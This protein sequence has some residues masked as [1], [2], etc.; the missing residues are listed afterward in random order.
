MEQVEVVEGMKKKKLQAVDS[1]MKIENG[2][3]ENAGVNHD[4]ASNEI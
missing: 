1:L 2:Y 3:E 4:T